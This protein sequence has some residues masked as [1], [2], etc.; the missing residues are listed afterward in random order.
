MDSTRSR[1]GSRRGRNA[2]Q[3]GLRIG[4]FLAEQRVHDAA[5]RDVADLAAQRHVAV[6][7]ARAEHE[8]VG[9]LE[10]RCGDPL[11][12]VGMVLAVGIR[13][14]DAGQ[15]GKGA[16]DMIE[17]GLERRAFAQVD[18]VPEQVNVR[19]RRDLRRKRVAEVG[20]AA[21]VHDHDRPGDGERQGRGR[22]R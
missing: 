6:E 17:R 21:I 7:R 15:F 4:E 12:I 9:A 1:R 2:A 18:G 11:D 10:Q 3:A 22:G 13:G 5:G 16:E 19:E 14:D 8:G 20:A